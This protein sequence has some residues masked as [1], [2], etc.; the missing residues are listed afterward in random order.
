MKNLIILA[1]WLFILF[2]CNNQQSQEAEWK[3]LF[4]GQDFSGWDQ[5][6]GEAEFK[7]EGDK[8]IGITKDDTPS[9]YLCTQREYEDFILELEVKMD[10]AM[11]S[12]IQIRSHSRPDYKSGKVHGWQIELDPSDRSWTGGV[13]NQSRG[14]WSQTLEDNPEAREAFKPMEWNTLKIKAEGE[15]IQSWVNGVQAAD[16]TDTLQ[17]RSGMICLQVHST[18]PGRW[19]AGKEIEFRNIR[20]KELE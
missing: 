6:G 20:I 8:I 10:T 7:I 18:I 13:F 9:S 5:R 14:G 3:S 11:N 1:C 4:N 17:N 12:G 15:S 2:S 19:P 16:Y